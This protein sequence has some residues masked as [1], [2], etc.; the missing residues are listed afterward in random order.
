ML[1]LEAVAHKQI[2]KF[3]KKKLTPEVFD[4]LYQ[5]ILGEFP[6]EKGEF[7]NIVV[8]SKEPDNKMY[9]SILGLIYRDGSYILSAP[10]KHFSMQECVSDFLQNPNALKLL[11]EKSSESDE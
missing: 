9:F 10:K 5:K 4:K 8:I 3:V 6:L 7:Q 11:T 2:A 1:G